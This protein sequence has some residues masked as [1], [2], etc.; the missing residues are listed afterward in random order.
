M[1]Q[2][3]PTA[4]EGN[5]SRQLSTRVTLHVS[6]NF[7]RLATRR[8]IIFSGNRLSVN[9]VTHSWERKFVYYSVDTRFAMFAMWLETKDTR[10]CY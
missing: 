10:P 7:S 4:G 5:V 3:L 8:S 2:T 9:V 6:Q 1:L